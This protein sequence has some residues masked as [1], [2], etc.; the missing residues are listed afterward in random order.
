MDDLGLAAAKQRSRRGRTMPRRRTIN[1]AAAVLA[2][3]TI[4]D[5][6]CTYVVIHVYGS[7]TEGNGWLADLGATIG[8]GPAMI[9]RGA[10]G[11][12]GMAILYF[13]TTLGSP[14]KPKL[15]RGARL[16]ARG[17]VLCALVFGAL[18]LY[19]VGGLYYTLTNFPPQ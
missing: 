4:A 14:S 13:F 7:A 9:V 3:G 12:L 1:I 17:M 10:L 6:I 5:A 15:Q 11:L 2:A 18:T 8:W 19:Q 16:A